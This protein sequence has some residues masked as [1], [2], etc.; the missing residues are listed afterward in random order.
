MEHAFFSINTSLEEHGCIAVLL[1]SDLAAVG[2]RVHQSAIRVLAKKS[3]CFELNGYNLIFTN[4][5]ASASHWISLVSARHWVQVPLNASL[6]RSAETLVVGDSPCHVFLCEYGF[7][8]AG[9]QHF[10]VSVT[11]VTHHYSMR[12]E[13]KYTVFLLISIIEQLVL[14][15]LDDIAVR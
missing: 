8:S 14:C 7:N 11:K 13:H 10:S 6:L 1:D 9:E 3:S 15:D 12:G 5:H 2:A 4:H